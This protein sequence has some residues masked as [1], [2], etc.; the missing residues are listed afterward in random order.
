MKKIKYLCW[1]FAAALAM[2]SCSED[3]L[4]PNSIFNTES[5]E[6]NEFDNW[7]LENYVAQYNIDLK[8]RFS[9]IE[10]DLNY[11][12]TPA[13]YNKSIALAQLVK[14]LWLDVYEELTYP[15]F[16]PTYC[17]KVMH[18]V[19]SGEYESNGSVVLGTA[20][21]GMKITLFNVN[22][23]DV[24]N[25]DIDVLNQWYFKTMHHEF[26]HILHQTKNY[27]TDFNE[28]TAGKYVGEDWVNWENGD[29]LLKIR[30]RGFVRGY[31]AKDPDEDFVETLATYVVYPDDQWQA[32]L[33]D[34]GE[35][36]SSLI[37]QKLDLITT[38]LTD[39]WGIDIEALHDL[40]QE[41]ASHVADMDWTTLK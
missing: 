23:L 20:E 21:G 33:K 11:N 22:S 31:V 18:F 37:L 29:A 10:S 6:R 8:Y 15:E 35:T 12:V 28:I 14:Y 41:R 4:N 38:Y 17:P 34:A 7:I 39:S 13:D 25:P 2:V 9:D 19:G 26:A 36:G 40:V 24:E 16:L 30:Q 3:E 5:P 1:I 32:L 27:S